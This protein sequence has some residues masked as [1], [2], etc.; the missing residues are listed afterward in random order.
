MKEEKKFHAA[1][2]KIHE[3]RKIRMSQVPVNVIPV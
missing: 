3:V 2:I 1:E